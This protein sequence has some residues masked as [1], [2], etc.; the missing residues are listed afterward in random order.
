LA[1]CPV[2]EAGRNGTDMTVPFYI[3]VAE[4]IRRRILADQYDQGDLI[5]SSGELEKEFRVSAI[6]IRKALET[7]TREGLLL[8][9]QGKGTSVRALTSDVITFELGA[10]FQRLIHPVEKLPIEVEV[11]E[12]TSLPCP[13]Q[14]GSTLS[15]PSKSDVWRVRKLRKAHDTPIAY[16]IHYTSRASCKGITR[17]DVGELNFLELFHK[18]TKIRVTSLRQTL[19]TVISDLDLSTVLNIRFGAPLFFI[20]NV[21]I[22]T[23]N[24]PVMLTQSYYRGDMCSYKATVQL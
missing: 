7:L 15:L 9:K 10:N 16:Y 22:S 8:R 17:K 5:P 21:Y 18:K 1:Q 11:L 4:T 2:P 6:T 13:P 12:I 23:E 20:E 19:K 24:K 3:Q 14:I